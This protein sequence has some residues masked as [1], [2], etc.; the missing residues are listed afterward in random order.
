[1]CSTLKGHFMQ[2]LKGNGVSD[3]GPRTEKIMN[4]LQNFYGATL[5]QNADYTEH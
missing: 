3:H 5:E 2:E 1:M 4:K